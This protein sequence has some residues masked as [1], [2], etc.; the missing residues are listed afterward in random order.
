MNKHNFF[1]LKKIVDINFVELIV[2]DLMIMSMKYIFCKC[3]SH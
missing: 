1:F 3:I 2:I